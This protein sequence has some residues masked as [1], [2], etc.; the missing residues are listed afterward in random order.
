MF[1]ISVNKLITI[2]KKLS[3]RN[4]SANGL[5]QLL[6][7]VLEVPCLADAAVVALFPALSQDYSL[8]PLDKEIVCKTIQTRE[9]YRTSL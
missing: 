5:H 7:V 1:L 4:L 8:K 2:E 3:F 9:I 6:T